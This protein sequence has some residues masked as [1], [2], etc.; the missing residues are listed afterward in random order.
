MFKFD[1]GR[2]SIYDYNLYRRR[3]AKESLVYLTN[4]IS[5]KEKKIIDI[6][7]GHGSN[8][9]TLA[10]GGA[11]VTAMDI[12]EDRLE[13]AK[14]INHHPNITY[15]KNPIEKFINEKFQ[16]VTIL[17]VLEHIENY[18]KLIKNVTSI[19]NKDSFIYIEYNPYF[20]FIGHH[21][22]DY[23]LLPVQLFPYEITKKIV[24]TKAKKGGIFSADKS[25]KQ[26]RDLNKITC[27]KVRKVLKENNLE[28]I[29]ERNH[30]SIPGKRS[31]N[32][33]LFRYLPYIEDLFSASHILI[34]K[35][36]KFK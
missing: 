34:L 31:I 36:N 19:I 22:Y 23:T 26:F 29:F 1:I 32:T 24:L 13:V 17:D 16:I 3:R 35:L 21:L 6:G 9:Y 18:E 28:I 4:F 33:G 8:A 14:K 20:S 7:C 10:I 12:D 11:N 25:L 30:I 15:T 5:L 2:E 27:R